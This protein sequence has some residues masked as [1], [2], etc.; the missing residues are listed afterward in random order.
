MGLKVFPSRGNFLLVQHQGREEAL[1]RFLQEGGIV[2]K[3]LP[4]L[5]VAGDALRVTVGVPEENDRL[6]DRLRGFLTEGG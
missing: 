6:L 2:V 5:P 3:F 1:W 4:R